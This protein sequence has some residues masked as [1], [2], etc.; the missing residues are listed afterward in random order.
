LAVEITGFEKDE[1]PTSVFTSEV[2]SFGGVK[3]AL[4]PH[5]QDCKI[6]KHAIASIRSLFF[7]KVYLVVVG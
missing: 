6:A 5:L 3:L 2:S 1:T 7:M 4:S